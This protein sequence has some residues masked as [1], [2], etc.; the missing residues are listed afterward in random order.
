[1]IDV[2]E[3][4]P[5]FK[6]RMYNPKKGNFTEISSRNLRG[7]WLI[8]NF[9]PAAFSSVCSTDLQAFA[10]KYEDFKKEN[11]EILAI[12]TDTVFAHKMWVKTSPRVEGVRYPLV[13]DV[14]KEITKSYDFLTEEGK[15]R[16][17]IVIVD[18]DGVIQYVSAFRSKLGKDVNH[19]YRAFMGLKY[20]HEHPGSEKEYDVIQANWE[21]DEEVEHVELPEDVGKF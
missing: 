17:G 21:P 12:S 7:K 16:R 6:A 9:V 4:A 20:L 2:G 8:L 18:P 19:I 15:A 1:M 3:K 5:D 11:S 14:K 10:E 13:G